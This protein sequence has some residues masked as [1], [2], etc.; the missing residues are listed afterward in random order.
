MT[1]IRPEKNIVERT[2]SYTE[3]RAYTDFLVSTLYWG[4]LREVFN[5]L[6][7]RQ[8]NTILEIGCGYG[9]LLPSLCQI[10]KKVIGSDIKDVFEFCKE[11]TLEKIKK[12]HENLELKEADARYL[13]SIM[14]KESCDIIVA[15]SVLEHI[16]EYEKVIQEVNECLK[17]QGIFVCVLPTENVLYRIGRSILRY[18][19]EYH[20]GYNYSKLRRSLSINFREVRIWFY[21]F[22]LPLFFYGAYRKKNTTVKCT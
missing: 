21:P 6:K 15:I 1:F 17:P 22:H 7:S 3:Y 10:G 9:Y 19:N 11:V 13:S 20:E 4:K 8:S 14:D 16:S 2:K 18:P 5:Y 12:N